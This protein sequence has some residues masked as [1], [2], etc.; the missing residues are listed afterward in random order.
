MSRSYAERLADFVEALRKLA[1][2]SGVSE[3]T[4]VASV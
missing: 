3:I 4:H 2:P 1:T